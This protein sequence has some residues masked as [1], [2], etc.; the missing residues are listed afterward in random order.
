MRDA[1]GVLD[2]VI[3]QLRVAV[4]ITRFDL[5]LSANAPLAEPP[6]PPLPPPTDAELVEQ[7]VAAASIA[8]SP[9]ERIGLL[10]TVMRL[11]DRAI[12]MMPGEWAAR[13]RRT[14]SGDLEREQRIEQAYDDLRT[15]TLEE[16]AKLAARGRDADLERL[17]DKV[18]EEDRRLGGQRAGDVAALLA[19][20]DLE[21]AAAIAAREA[22]Q[23]VEQRAPVFRRYRRSTNGAFKVFNDA[24][25]ALEQVKAMSGPPVTTIGPLTKR[26]A[27]RA[28]ASRKCGAGG[29]RVR[30]RDDRQR[31]GAGAERVPAA[32]RS[33][34]GQQHRRRAARLVCGGRGPDA[35][36]ARARRSAHRHGAAGAASDHPSSHPAAARARP[37]RL[38]STLVDL[39]RALDPATAADTFVLV[40]TTRRRR[41]AQRERSM[42]RLRRSRASAAHRLARGA[43]TTR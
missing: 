36:S 26:L 24:A 19:T 8:E 33:G 22:R 1:L 35:V 28:A 38:S 18:R 27:R 39:A 11:I 6:P 7:F 34:V 5:S 13:M 16:A 15:R 41:T 14:V 30:A 12:G 9:V 20:I 32:P 10:Q 40:P 43:C 31:V 37:G 2:E 21:A 42:Q 25:I 23:G 29:A 17:R 4:G 3:A